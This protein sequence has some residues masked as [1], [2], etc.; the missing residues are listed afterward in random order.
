MKIKEGAEPAWVKKFPAN[1]MYYIGIG[2]GKTLEQAQNA[3]LNG[4]A[5]QIKVKIQSEITDYTKETNGVTDEQVTQNIKLNVK[6]SLEEF[7][8]VDS[9]YSPEKAY[10]TYYRL[11]IDK[12]K[13]KQREKMEKAKQIA[14]D[15]LTKC[16]GESDVAL[17][18]K[19]AFLG[20][21]NVGK[22]V[23]ASLKANYK[24]GE[25]IITNELISRMQK[26][27][28][29]IS[30]L[31]RNNEVEIAKIA[32]KPVEVVFDITSNSKALANFPVKFY[33]N[34]GELDITKRSSTD[35]NGN[36]S[37]IINRAIK[38]D[39]IQSFVSELDI[40]SFIEGATEDEEE[41]TIFFGRLSNLGIP[42]KEVVVK[43]NP[44]IM[45]FDLQVLNDLG[46]NKQARSRFDTLV[47]AFKD[48]FAQ[49]TGV[50][51]T[52]SGATLKLS[53]I[54]DGTITQSDSGQ[55]FTKVLVTVAISDLKS[56]EELF[57]TTSQEIKQWLCYRYKV[58]S[59]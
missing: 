46:K 30:M 12:Y 54:L 10:W 38:R 11:D 24:G 58:C 23:S 55:F 14:L 22:Y 31:P 48:S 4:I 28:S 7:E 59:A 51:F 44:P 50:K 34:K 45:S 8:I 5:S 29:S 53:I 49:D 21:Y 3:S 27:L 35:I 40:M 56:G 17:A 1:P 19:Y 37:C 20:Y 32:P 15:Y 57:T 26:I 36:V 52:D 6:E 18:F 13:Q 33:S 16:D 25:I 39:A 9:W 2:T 41:A 43:V 42:S 47:T